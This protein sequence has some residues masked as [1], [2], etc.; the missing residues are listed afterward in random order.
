M[1]QVTIYLDEE[2]EG[3]MRA[4]AKAMRMSKSKWVAKIIQEKIS[5]VWPD[6]V[7]K[8]GG[9]WKDFPTVEEIRK[10]IGKDVKRRGL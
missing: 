4:A 1:G 10:S 6:S 9:A 2:T 8:L 3:K 7:K 5:D